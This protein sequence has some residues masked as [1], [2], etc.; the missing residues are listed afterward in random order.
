MAKG[1]R[2]SRLAAAALVTTPVEGFV[3]VSR[4]ETLGPQQTLDYGKRGFDLG[5][6]GRQRRRELQRFAGDRVIQLERG[7]VQERSWRRDAR[8]H[9][10]VRRIADDRM[11][12]RREVNANLMRT[13]GLQTTLEA[14]ASSGSDVLLQA[15]DSECALALPATTTAMR[16]GSRRSRPIGA[17][18]TPF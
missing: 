1:I 4:H 15:P 5:E 11:T 7:R 6:I 18:I 12:D 14:A 10:A 16:I 9:A 3:P 17:S 13:A 2:R 8:A